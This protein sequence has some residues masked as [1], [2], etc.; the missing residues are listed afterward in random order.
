MVPSAE[1]SNPDLSEGEPK[2]LAPMIPSSEESDPKVMESEPK[3]F[4][5]MMPAAREYQPSFAEYEPKFED[6]QPQFTSFGN[7]DGNNVQNAEESSSS[8]QQEQ[9]TGDVPIAEQQP[10]SQV[11]ESENQEEG[12]QRWQNIDFWPNKLLKLS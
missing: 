1:E 10:N 12:S 6:Y 11:G 8:A 7:S 5:P 4:A 3:V 9:H 2:V